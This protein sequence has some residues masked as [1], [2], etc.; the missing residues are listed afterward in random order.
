MQG[1]RPRNLSNRELISY[2]AKLMEGAYGELLGMPY[3]WQVELLRRF[4]A[5]APMDEHPP[6][7][8]KQLN[9]F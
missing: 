2:C 8:P 3:E 6:V 4:N 1:I 9:L 5:L 7:D